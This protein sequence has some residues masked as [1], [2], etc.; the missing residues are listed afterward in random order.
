MKMIIETRIR[1]DRI[2][3]AKRA[4]DAATVAALEAKIDT[5]VFRFFGL[6]PEEIALELGPAA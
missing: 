1:V 4:G 3:A 5:H 6:T 2:L